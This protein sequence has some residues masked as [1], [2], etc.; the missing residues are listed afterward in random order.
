MTHLLSFDLQKL[1]LK[2]NQIE[3]LSDGAFYVSN[4]EIEEISLDR[5]RITNVQKGWMY[6]L[7]H[8]RYLSLA[9]NQIDYIASDGWDPLEKLEELDL[10]SN[11]LQLLDRESLCSLPELRFL[12]L[13]DNKISHIDGDE[14][15]EYCSLRT[16]GDVPLLE[17]LY[18]DGNE[19]SHTIEVRILSPINTTET[20]IDS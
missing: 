19:I 10:R 6:G 20:F 4:G 16:F 11:K 8:L 15:D 2:R 18:L 9:N 3:F 5:N 12:Y 13:Q 17:E 7:D 14:G 1:R